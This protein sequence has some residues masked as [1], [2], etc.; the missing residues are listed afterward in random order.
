[1]DPGENSVENSPHKTNIFSGVPPK[2]IGKCKIKRGKCL[3]TWI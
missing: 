1:M 2:L 3:S